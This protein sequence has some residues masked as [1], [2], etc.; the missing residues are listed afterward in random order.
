MM[1]GLEP[2]PTCTPRKVRDHAFE[3]AVMIGFFLVGVALLT[4][5]TRAEL[6][7]VGAVVEGW[8]TVWASVY[9]VVCPS[10]LL[11]IARGSSR[12]RVAGLVL[13][14]SAMLMQGTAA[15]VLNTFDPRSWVYVV[16]SAACVVRAVAVARFVRQGFP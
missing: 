5:P 1:G 7:P 8:S 6:S 12:L 14:A 11:A 16:F 9:V 13:V 2:R 10:V 15:V 3:I 4:D